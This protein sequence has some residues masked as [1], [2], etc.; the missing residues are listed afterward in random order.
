MKKTLTL[1]ALLM[2]AGPQAMADTTAPREVWWNGVTHDP[3]TRKMEGAITTYKYN[4]YP[5]VN[6][7]SGMCWVASACNLIAWWQDRVEENGALII[8]EG[9]P[10]DYK[11]FD[12]ERTLWNNTSGGYQ[13]YAIQTWLTGSSKLNLAQS[14]ATQAGLNFAGYYPR[15]AGAD[16]GMYNYSNKRG[17]NPKTAA[18]YPNDYSHYE[19]T[20]IQT[21]W[22]LPSNKDVDNPEKTRYQWASETIVEFME[23][24]WA[25][26]WAT[27]THAMTVYGVEL[28]EKGL[29]TKFF[30]SDNNYSSAGYD[31]Y[32]ELSISMGDEGSMLTGYQGSAPT[33]ANICALR[34]TGIRFLD[35]D[36]R[37]G[38]NL[39]DDNEFLFSHYCNLIVDG[40]DDYKLQYDLRDASVK[41]SP[42]DA[43]K[44]EQYT[45]D[46]GFGLVSY[47]ERFTDEVVTT[48]D[49]LLRGGKVTLVNCAEDRVE[50]DGGGKVAGVI[51]FQ[52][53]VV[54]GTTDTKQEADRTLK[55][56][57][58]DTIAKEINLS[59][60]KGTNTLEVTGSN[61]A[62]FGKLTGEGNLD[63]TGTGTAKVTD[64]VELQGEIHVKE[65]DFIFGKDVELTGNTKLTVS[66]GAHVQGAEGQDITLTITSGVQVNDGVLALTTTVKTGATLKGSGTFAAVTV[67]GGTL[68][69]GNSPGRQTYTEAL[70]VNMGD[71]IFSV[72][73]WNTAANG[74]KFGWGSGT[75]SNIVMGEGGALTLNEGAIVNFAVG[76]DA[77]ANLLGGEG[78]FSM[79]I[80]TGIGN[81]DVFTSAFLQHLALQ[82][83]FYVATEDGADTANNA[84]LNAGA[85]LTARIYNLAYSFKDGG[86]L[87]LSGSF[88]QQVV[89]EPATGT[90]SLLALAGLAARRRR[91]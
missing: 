8:P 26:G 42:V 38:K 67:D 4:T 25:V 88:E 89:P 22:F 60:T 46:E 32:T 77:L 9:T 15:L 14:D 44:V 3:T 81:T 71:I 63:K 27:S 82:T 33:L 74:E 31:C 85:D 87:S 68:I 29:I 5:G 54:K 75:Y 37:V 11:I 57:R 17:V 28:D 36:V 80:A 62:T 53:S 35:Y 43:K 41:G 61:T 45:E 2:I 13:G 83:K 49:M 55:V 78:S 70:T 47:H 24:D 72:D 34:S 52:D 58:T 64:A 30:N 66:D 39:V 19:Y 51:R 79:D 69:V 6:S 16:L 18:Q 91:K 59:A 1:L 76:G 48:G 10:R 20:M 7:D 23:D 86:V 50:L 90:L 40:E 73:G 21:Y 56:D 84:G 65:G 12:V